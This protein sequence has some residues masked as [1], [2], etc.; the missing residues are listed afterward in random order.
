MLKR[1][2]NEKEKKYRKNG[3]ENACFFSKYLI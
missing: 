2:E 1:K 3:E